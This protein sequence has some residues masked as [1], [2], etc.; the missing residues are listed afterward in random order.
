VR[1]KHWAKSTGRRG[2]RREKCD[3]II[4]L[5]IYFEFL[6]TNFFDNLPFEKCRNID[7]IYI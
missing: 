7:Y 2:R 6:K 1:E 3:N 5:V 4:T